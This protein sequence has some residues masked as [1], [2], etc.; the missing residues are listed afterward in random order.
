MKKQR[1][2]EKSNQMRIRTDN[3]KM[4]SRESIS[5]VFNTILNTGEGQI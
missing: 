5:D 2:E 3:Q 1:Q 4:P